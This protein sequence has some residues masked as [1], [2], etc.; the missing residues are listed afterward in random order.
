MDE[1]TFLWTYL[2]SKAKKILLYKIYEDGVKGLF[3]RFE[4]FV[5]IFDQYLENVE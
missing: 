5:A 4:K 3:L 2:T 1:V